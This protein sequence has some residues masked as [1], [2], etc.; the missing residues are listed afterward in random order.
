VFAEALLVAAAA[1]V[2]GELVMVGEAVAEL[3]VA[4][5]ADEPEPVEHAASAMLRTAG[6]KKARWIDMK[7]RLVLGA[8]RSRV[9]SRIDRGICR[10]GD[11]AAARGGRAVTTSGGMS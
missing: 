7:P 1:D 5:V 3:V 10:S 4:V 6:R 2:E 9:G 8:T 11:E